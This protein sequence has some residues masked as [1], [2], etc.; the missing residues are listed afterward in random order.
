MEKYYFATQIDRSVVDVR[1]AAIWM[2]CTPNLLLKLSRSGWL[3]SVEDIEPTEKNGRRHK[4]TFTVGAL[5]MITWDIAY[6]LSFYD[7]LAIRKSKLPVEVIARRGGLP[8]RVVKTVQDAFVFGWI[9]ALLHRYASQRLEGA[10]YKPDIKI[11]FPAN[12][13][14]LPVLLPKLSRQEFL[15]DCRGSA[16]PLRNVPVKGFVSHGCIEMPFER[17]LFSKRGLAVSHTSNMPDELWS[18][19]QLR[20]EYLLL[21]QEVETLRERP[22]EPQCQSKQAREHK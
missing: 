5:R 22:T 12:P 4:K 19:D 9:V 11:P 8:V 7:I 6:S 14:S 20:Q 17:K 18:L 2:G 1:N 16:N 13:F 3:K 10:V 21:L 15:A